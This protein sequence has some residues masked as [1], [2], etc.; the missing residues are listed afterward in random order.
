MLS[1]VVRPGS[2]LE[3][4]LVEFVCDAHASADEGPTVTPLRVGWGYCPG[5]ERG[6]H[7]W[8]HIEPT[9]R[10]RLERYVLPLRMRSTV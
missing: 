2:A 5:A 1:Q 4:G 7:R 6:D 9:T 3:F 10:E 8:R